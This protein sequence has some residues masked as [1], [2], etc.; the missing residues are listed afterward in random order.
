MKNFPNFTKYPLVIKKLANCSILWD[1]VKFVKIPENWKITLKNLSFFNSDLMYQFQV[2]FSGLVFY[3][4]IW[5]R[6]S[7]VRPASCGVQV[8][9]RCL[10]IRPGWAQSLKKIAFSYFLK[11]SKTLLQ[12]T[13][14]FKKLLNFSIFWYWRIF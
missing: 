1:L 8:M 6:S 3:A 9:F 7:S 11:N 14:F 2:N 10:W 13:E 12:F 4:V 5:T